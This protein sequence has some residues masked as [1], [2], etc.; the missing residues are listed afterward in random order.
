MPV[1]NPWHG[2]EK[3]S[4]G[5]QNC[6]VYRLDSQFGKDSSIIE[7]TASF[8]LPICKNK[9]GE[10]K[11]ATT[12]KKI[13]TCMT[14]DFFLS[15]ADKWRNEAWQMIRQRKDIHFAII[16]KRIDRFFV[17]LPDDWGKGYDNVTIICT[18]ENQE[19]ADKR[20]NIFLKLPIIH[21]EIIHEPLL[22]K[23]N[24][25][26]YL[27]TGKI[28]MVTCGGESGKN[29]RLCDYNWVM[30]IRRQCLKYK[31]PFNFKQTGAKFKKDGKI[32]NIDRKLQITQAK[33]ASID[34][35]P[36][37]DLE[38]EQSVQLM[39][40]LFIRL[41]KSEFRSKFKLADKERKYISEKGIETIRQHARDFICKR[42]A[43]A[44]PLKDGK[45]T[46]MKGHPVFIAQ[47]AT[48]TC[49]R[50]CLLKWHGI[51][52]GIQLTEDQQ[53]YIVSVIMEWI[54]RQLKR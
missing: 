45:Q 49:C 24:I 13:Y 50:G 41:G 52:K 5:C 27:A 25:E 37:Q 20:L 31:V 4:P 21:R 40:N 9:N 43:P 42:L 2:C 8:N 6:Y 15:K 19:Q 23:I 17:S 18:C 53:E 28:H 54:N 10:Y 38:I 3:I 30:D 44:E 51:Q 22:E 1:W 33:R 7:K 35:Y 11:L 26:P 36:D 34:Y 12:D 14:S 32:Y 46:P 16:T 39:N 29:A 48:G 47:H